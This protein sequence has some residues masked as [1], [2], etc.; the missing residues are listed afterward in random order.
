MFHFIDYLRLVRLVNCLL[1]MIGVWVGAYLTWSFPVYYG[2]LIASISAGLVCAAGNAVN[3]LVDI[4][5]D[6]TNHPQRVLVRGKVSTRGALRLALI[7]NL[8][9][10]AIAATVSLAVTLLALV[11]IGLLTAY[12][13][14]L[15]R[16]PL[17]GNSLIALLSG[18]IF[19]SGGLAVDTSLAFRLPGPLIPMVFAFFFHLVRE[20]VK[21]VSDIEG[22][23][24]RGI[25]SLP[26]VVGVSR[27]LILALGLFALL[28]IL[29]Y[30]PIFAGWFGRSY[31]I[32]TVYFVD[33]PLLAFLI[34]MWG[35]PSPRMLTVGSMA[36]KVG[37]GLGLVALLVA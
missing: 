13:L 6:R 11:A 17:L 3:D 2:P 7:L 20:I 12:N 5:G 34:F 30:L 22:D 19:L 35:N 32:I 9:A 26:Q 23:R 4:E 14:K 24:E 29:T 16:V 36:L 10:V 27:S 8:L 37:M 1:A 33:L 21:D 18:L 15:K 31:E 25:R 28:V